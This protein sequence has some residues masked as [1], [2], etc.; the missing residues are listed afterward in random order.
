MIV[1]EVMARTSLKFYENDLIEEVAKS[2]VKQSLKGGLVYNHFDS[3]IG[4]FTETEILFGLQSRQTR[5]KEI[6]LPSFK[7]I[8]ETAKI[9]EVDFGLNCMNPVMNREGVIVGYITKEQYLEAYAKNTQIQLKHLDAIFNST[10]NGILSIDA[11]GNITSINPPAEKMAKTTKEK[12]I[13][14][15]LT[16]V[17]LPAGLLEVVRTGKGHTEKYRAG[18]R[19]YITN[20]SPIIDENK[21]IG[22]VGVFQDI[23][24]IEFIS[25]ELETVK[26]IVNE[27]DTIINTSNDGI[28]IMN[29][30]YNIIKMNKKFSRIF[31]LTNKD[32][33]HLSDISGNIEQFIHGV[34]KSRKASS[35]LKKNMIISATPILDHKKNVNRVVINVKDMTEM[36]SLRDELAKTKKIL[37]SLNHQNESGFIYCS[38]TMKNL[39]KTVHQVANVDVTVLLTGESGVGKGEIANL[40]WRSSQRKDQPFVKVN[41]GAIPESLI[42]SELFGYEPGAFTGASRKGKKGFF[43]QSDGGTIFLD[44][45]GEI[46]QHLQVK[47]LRVL[48]EMEITRI[49][50]EKSKKI[51]TRIIAATNKD[52]EKL[53]I[54][55]IF[56][57][58]LFY[59]LNVIPIKVPSL[60]RRKE[61]IPILIDYYLKKFSVKYNK[62]VDFS[63]DAIK[64]FM[65]H[66]WPGNVR[67]LV[68]MIERIFVTTTSSVVQY[69]DL[70]Q[71]LNL[72]PDLSIS[73]FVT[74]NQIFPLKAA[75]EELEKQLIAKALQKEKTYRK[76]AKLL[77]VNASTIVRKIQKYEKG[78]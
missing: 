52:L 70:V 18:K 46:P 12:A 14:E 33:Y 39:I 25:N 2:L 71:L 61:D 22:A 45:I 64:A 24:D 56:R 36:E 32:N 54:E 40:I 6:L 67:E 57:E 69:D 37:S 38:P 65:N 27:L 60:R 23:S 35:I 66:D 44:E 47:L 31:Q 21:V 28:C 48:Q 63:N 10:H 5:L 26:Q 59:R 43:E 29:N 77:E 4:V 76:A 51:D 55:G 9:N 72:E 68:N 42:E 16:D 74:V 34:I 75:V 50:A 13:G 30:Q 73:E 41:C 3:L 53:V 7:M 49:G 58:D 20:R 62:N 19:T 8:E 78:N 15:F 17:V 1:K 11:T